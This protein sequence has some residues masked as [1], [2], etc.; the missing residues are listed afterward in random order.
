MKKNNPGNN[1]NQAIKKAK[2]ETKAIVCPFCNGSGCPSCQ[3]SGQIQ[4]SPEELAQLQAL[5]Q[6]PI[7]GM[8]SNIPLTVPQAAALKQ[9]IRRETI[10]GSRITIREVKTR[11]AGIIAFLI[12]AGLIMGGYLSNRHFGSY[13]PYLAAILSVIILFT[14][15]IAGKKEFFQYQEPNDFLSNMSKLHL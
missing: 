11:T 15:F 4:A 13:E 14:G 6:T 12:V 2:G 8:P 1:I 5:M 3:N 10:P 7:P 9:K